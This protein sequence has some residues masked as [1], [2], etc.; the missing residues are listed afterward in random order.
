MRKKIRKSRWRWVIIGIPIFFILSGVGIVG[1]F[2]W[3]LSK[4]TVLLAHTAFTPYKPED[5]DKTFQQAWSELPEPGSKIGDLVFK[6]L[7]YKVPVVQGTHDAEL[8]SG[9]GHFAGSSLP[10]QDGNVVLSGH[11]NTS[12]RK[13]EYLK[14]GDSIEFATPYGNF[15]YEITDFKITNA[16]DETIIVPTNYETLTLTTCYPFEY[17]GDA[18]ARFVVFTKILS[19]PD[20]DKI[21]NKKI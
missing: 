16:K 11:R 19:K 15:I 17:I 20:L 3:E 12:F 5:P 2:G 14:M 1:F 10:G 8:K 9:V 6:T 7:D 21:Q 13:L 4:Q 18:P